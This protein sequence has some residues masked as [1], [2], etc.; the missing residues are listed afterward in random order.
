MATKDRLGRWSHSLFDSLDRLNS[1]T[2]A[3]GRI[4]QFIW[5][6]CGNLSEIV[7]Q[8]KHITTFTYDIQSRLTSK[9]YDDGK[10]ITYK[11]DSTTSR[12][13]QVTD[14]KG[15]TTKYTYFIDD[16]LRQINYTN[17][18]I[19]TPSVIFSY[20]GKYNRITA[21]LDGSGITSY[22]YYPVTAG[23][24]G[25][26]RLKTID[27]PLTNDNIVYTYDKLGR[28]K[29]RAIN[30]ILSSVVYDSLGRITSATNALGNFT[31]NYVDVTNRLASVVYPNG[32]NTAF[33]YFDNLGDQRLKEIW[34]KNGSTTISKFDY[35]YDKEGQITKWTQ[36]TDNTTPKYYELGYDHADQLIYATQKNQNT[37]A[38]LK[39]YA[40]QY[41]KAGNRTNEQIDNSVTSAIYDS[42][43]QMTAQQ[44]GGRMFFKG[45]INEFA[46]VQIKNKTAS[47]S[48]NATVDS[49]TNSFQGF[50]KILPGKKN[51]IFITAVDYS[52]NNN[53]N[54]DTFNVNTGH[55]TNNTLSFD[56]NGNTISETNPAVTYSWDAA[57][58]LVK[59]VKGANTEEFIYDGL[60]R[61]VAE[62]LNGTI[63][64]RWLWCGTELCEERDASG[65]TVTKRFF[66]QGEQINGTNYFFTKDHLGSVREVINSSGNLVT[67]YDYDPYGRRTKLTGTINADFGFTGHYIDTLSNLYLALYRAYDANLGRWLSRDPIQETK[68][69][70]LYEYG[71][72]NPINLVDQLGLQEYGNVNLVHSASFS[73]PEPPRLPS[74]FQYYGNWGGPGWAGG[75]WTSIGHQLE[76][77]TVEEQKKLK[78]PIDPEDAAYKDHDY[79]YSHCRV[80][81]KNCPSK[82]AECF[83]QCDRQL[84]RD[85]LN[86]EF[87]HYYDPKTGDFTKSYYDIRAEIAQEYFAQSDPGPD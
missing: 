70:N 75:M 58:R 84:S 50:V 17:A 68:G 12:L 42:L 30:N 19:A 80:K 61:R 7:D 60:S 3:L 82:R 54:T 4:T 18:A 86:L 29:S 81:Y 26:G 51:K 83:K 43:N 24:I 11:Y 56:D 39:R 79:C 22:S 63:I 27:G 15:Q 72:N 73:K 71:L 1:V 47:G 64:K 40:Y 9:I 37:N 16:N 44:D 53:T 77:L 69:I 67:R 49:L 74:S 31:Y 62:K 28:V 8:F 45:T 87:T 57:D 78:D 85:L 10:T 23:T 21:M 76:D 36:Q 41:N 46:S 32:Q 33:T 25:A 38:I 35:E 20:D 13:A 48:V 65:S 6:A 59:I 52:G 2:D 5:C 34:N 66:P 55:G 14:A